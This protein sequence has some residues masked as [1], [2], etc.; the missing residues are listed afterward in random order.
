MAYRRGGTAR[1]SYKATAKRRYAGRSK[2][3]RS[4]AKKRTYRKRL[5]SIKA[6]L[7]VT[8]RKKRN[9]MLSWSNTNPGTGASQTIAAGGAVVAGNSVGFFLFSPTCMNLNQGSSNPTYF[10]NSA[11][12]TSTTC[13][14]RGFSETLRIQTNSHVPW[15][16]RRICF[17]FRGATPFASPNSSDTPTQNMSPYVDT[18]N[19]MERLWLNQQVNA[20]GQSVQAIWGVLFKGMINQDWN[21]V[22]IAPVDTTRVDLKFDKTWLIKSGNESGTIVQRKLWHPMNKNLVYDDDET[23]ES[24]ASQYYS[25]D[26]K[27]GMGDFYVY[28]IITPGLG[29]S[30]TD[31]ISIQANSTMYWHEK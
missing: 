28:D 8:S 24:M 26:S 6:V 11:E 22:V 17:C 29:G 7:N 27:Q 30:A 14:M 16:H 21:D 19:G 23:G 2:F 31:L 5:I 3:R 18:S 20:M 1:K 25:V 13:Y 9:G 15:F 10:I 12:R 4:Y